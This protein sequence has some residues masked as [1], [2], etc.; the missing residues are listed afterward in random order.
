M[1]IFAENLHIRIGTST[2]GV[3]WALFDPALNRGVYS[4]IRIADPADAIGIVRCE[5]RSGALGTLARELCAVGLP[6]R[7]FEAWSE[8][9]GAASFRYWGSSLLSQAKFAYAG[10]DGALRR[11]SWRAYPA[12]QQKPCLTCGH[13]D[14]MF[15]SVCIGCYPVL[16]MPVA[17]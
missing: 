12:Q 4:A 3:D 7:P 9:G 17:L 1:N 14:L 15:K 5:S 16:N 11:V 10:G 6:D 8:K 2:L 13:S